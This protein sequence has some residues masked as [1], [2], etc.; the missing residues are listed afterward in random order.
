MKL[1]SQL[2]TFDQKLDYLLAPETNF[3]AR[4]E[5][6]CADD[7]YAIA[8]REQSIVLRFEDLVGAAGG[9]DDA[10]QMASLVKL[11]NHICR[12]RIA[13]EE[14]QEVANRS[15]GGKTFKEGGHFR[16]DK[17]G[18]GENTSSRGILQR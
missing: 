10:R 1:W 11:A 9:G 7:S 18:N 3:F 2:R 16:K 4:S 8:E 12:K 5:K 6:V 14:L 13:K 15:F 17:L